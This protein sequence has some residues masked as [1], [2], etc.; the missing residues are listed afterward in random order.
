M[1]FLRSAIEG[2]VRC[3]KDCLCFPLLR[4]EFS[5]MPS[6]R[7]ED[8]SPPL[9]LPLIAKHLHRPTDRRRSNHTNYTIHP[10]DRRSIINKVRRNNC[11]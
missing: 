3:L 10:L 4:S 11:S 7:G 8:F 9:I 6:A 1:S 5:L 2:A